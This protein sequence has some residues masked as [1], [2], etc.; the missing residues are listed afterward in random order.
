LSSSLYDRI[1]DQVFS[2]L[3]IRDFISEFYSDDSQLYSEV[4]KNRLC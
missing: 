3:E 2:N 4:R 1:S